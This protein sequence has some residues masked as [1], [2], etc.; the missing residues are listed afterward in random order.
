[1]DF[2]INIERNSKTGVYSQIASQI[3]QAVEDGLLLPGTRLPTER[4]LGESL[5][6]ARGTVSKAYD[7]LRKNDI[8]EVIQG[9]GSYVKTKA[10]ITNG[11][12]KELVASYI[13]EF[14]GK[15]QELNITTDEIRALIDIAISEKKNPQRKVTIATIDCNEES[16]AVFKEQFASFPNITVKIFLIDDILKYSSPE[17]VFQYYDIIITTI[18]HYEQ[19]AGILHSLK[20][21]VCKAAVS[22][23]QET[24]ISISTIPKDHKIGIIVRS[25]N[26]K[27]L[28]FTRLES[29]NID[30]SKV[31]FAFDDDLRKLDKLLIESDVLITPHFL[32]QD[33][34]QL[35][36]QL[37]YFLGRGGNLIDFMYRIEE[38]S[39]IYIEERIKN[40]MAETV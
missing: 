6:L 27:N 18:T 3:Q 37:H 34:V 24:V 20:D 19:I 1:M 35:A 7:V 28:M 39:L 40:L 36:R 29:M 15:M 13:E 33:N 4:E 25:N 16:L 23:T 5:N 21:R 26:F 31:K 11:Y 9:S 30:I 32:L 12:K 10:E 14:L 2:R 17:K 38:G 8:I 22:P